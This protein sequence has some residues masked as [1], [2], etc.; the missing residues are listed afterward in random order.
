MKKKRFIDVTRNNTYYTLVQGPDHL[1]INIF[2]PYYT[3]NFTE[4]R[5]FLLIPIP[6]PTWVKLRVLQVYNFGFFSGSTDSSLPLVQSPNVLLPIQ[7][8]SIFELAV[9]P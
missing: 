6:T 2:A 7:T 8:F 4:G 5:L 1:V 9:V 3:L